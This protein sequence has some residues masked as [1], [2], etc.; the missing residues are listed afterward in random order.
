MAKKSAPSKRRPQPNGRG[1]WELI[2]GFFGWR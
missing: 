1:I 2:G